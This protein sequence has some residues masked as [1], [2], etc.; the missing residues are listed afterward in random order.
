[1]IKQK[2]LRRILH[3]DAKRGVWKWR[4]SRGTAGKGSIAGSANSHGY[5]SIKINGKLYKSYRLA[6]FYI[7]GYFPEHDVDHINRVRDDDRWCNL[8][9]V[10][11][12]CNLRNTGNPCINTSGVKGVDW[13]KRAGKWRARIKGNGKSKSLGYHADFAEAVAHR[14]AAEQCL[15]WEGC[16]SSSPAFRH[17]EEYC[18]RG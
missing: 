12:T 1:M 7:C 10:S 8:R 3:Y 18:G 6:W 5:R 13:V 2:E 4:V 14:L 17:M 16:D 11:R 9:E 15:D